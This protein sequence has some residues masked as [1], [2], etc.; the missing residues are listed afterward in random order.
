MNVHIRS[1]F[2]FHAVIRTQEAEAEAGEAPVTSLVPPTALL[3]GLWM[4]TAPQGTAG[5][6]GAARADGTTAVPEVVPLVAPAA[7]PGVAPG[8]AV[9][10]VP[11]AV[12]GAAVGVVRLVL[13]S[14]L[15]K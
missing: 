8:A 4:R 7:V 2:I 9:G 3:A 10:V 14:A 13:R 15:E 6:S 11:G 1:L 5:L 12:P